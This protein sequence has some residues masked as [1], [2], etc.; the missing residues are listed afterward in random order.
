MKL[1]SFVFLFIIFMV[2]MILFQNCEGEFKAIK[3]SNHPLIT[4]SLNCLDETEHD[5]CVINKNS[6]YEKKEISSLAGPDYSGLLLKPVNLPFLDDSGKLQNNTFR[7]L[8]YTRQQVNTTHSPLRF[9]YESDNGVALSQVTSYYYS[10]LATQFSKKTNLSLTGYGLYI[11]TQAPVT[12]WSAEDNTIYLGLNPN[13]QHDSSLDAS[14]LLNLLSEAN[15]YYASQGAIYKETSENHKDCRGKEEMCCINEKGCSKALTMGLSLYFS[16]HFFKDSPTVGESYS[17]SLTGMEDCGISRSLNE[18]RDVSISEAFNACWTKGYVYPM[19]TVYASI[20]WNV[21][22][23]IRDNK[24]Q[25]TKEFQTFYLEHL[26]RLKGSF[27]FMDAFHSIEELD[28]Q[29]FDSTFAPY[30]KKEL[31]R[32]GITI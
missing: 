17:N 32:R 5:D 30:F 7:V 18:S 9:S 26:K 15:I 13:N 28:T 29:D 25:K 27:N 11:I 8:S 20:W 1:T 23:E 12:G 4:K 16:S 14:I 22:K 21:H 6:V 31:I 2:G 3:S 24:P 10:S 19:A